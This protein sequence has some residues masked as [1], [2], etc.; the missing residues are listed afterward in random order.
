MSRAPTHRTLNATKVRLPLLADHPPA[1]ARILETRNAG[2]VK[3]LFA[4]DLYEE[5]LAELL[6][7]LERGVEIRFVPTPAAGYSH[8]TLLLDRALRERAA[9]AATGHNVRV[10]TLALTAFVRYLARHQVSQAA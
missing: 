9:A 10:G 6:D 2:A 7:E 1:F 5:A 8:M 3:R 4:R